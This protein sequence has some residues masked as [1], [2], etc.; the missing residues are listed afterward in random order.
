MR[1][2]S[3]LATVSVAGFMAGCGFPAKDLNMLEKKADIEWVYGVFERNY[4]PADW[5]KTQ[6]GP[7]LEQAKQTC[8]DESAAIT[9]ADEFISH[10]SKCVNRFGDAHTRTLA[11]GA[12]LP[13]FAKV[14]YLGF[15]TEGV[16]IDMNN[17]GTL[18]KDDKAQA[19]DKD[20]VSVKAEMNLQLA[21]KVRDLLPTTDAADFPIK[22]GDFIVAIDNKTVEEY[23]NDRLVPFGNLGQKNSSL[24]V[25]AHS[26]A[27]RSSYAVPLPTESDVSLK[28][29]REGKVSTVVLPWSVK[30]ALTFSQE[31]TAARAAKEATPVAKTKATYALR[32]DGD[33]VVDEMMNLFSRF[34]NQAGFRISLLLN[35]TFGR[36]NLNPTLHFLQDLMG[37]SETASTTLPVEDAF[38][39]ATS[40]KIENDIFVARIIVMDD[41]T[42]I[43]YV[44]LESFSIP[45]DAGDK[46]A[47][48]HAK[49]SKMKVKGVIYDALNNGGG[50]LVAGLRMANKMTEK[51]IKYPGMQLAL[52]ENWVNAFHADSLYMP[53]SEGSDARRTYAARVYSKLQEDQK[54]GLRLS[55]PISTTELDPF[56]LN[57]DKSKC[58][59]EG[60]CLS[61]DIKKVLLVNEMCA[62]MCD[63]FAGI[64]R[65]NKMGT[66]IGSQ[67]MGAGG[68]V[69]LHGISPVTQIMMTQ[70]ESLIV[71]SQG[72][73]LENRGVLPNEAIDTMYDE[74]KKFAD[75]YA[76][77]LEVINR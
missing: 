43:G 5:K 68:N 72:E 69:V 53:G 29:V 48:I 49:F 13:E 44:R 42:R 70:T 38:T 1:R 27:V 74:G 54:A 12:M 40:L 6:F 52:N 47:D 50:S 60:K 4:A 75:T 32:W 33:A 77:A 39:N 46:L 25:G 23:L 41:G 34:R 76:K 19:K 22:A 17:L 45:S 61:D 9:K 24:S 2:L 8:L 67:T 28:I 62:S 35:N 71:D 73:Y 16:R 63:I 66:I 10:L 59:A 18:K 26:F 11:G 31:Q 36:R 20:K 55:R 7:S 37:D 64:F 65:D 14:A 30:D 57:E 15:R 58:K 21:L 3:L 56:V 51:E